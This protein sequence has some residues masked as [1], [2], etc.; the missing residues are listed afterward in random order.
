M[1]ER[2]IMEVQ[3]GDE[4]NEN[5][6][7]EES[8]QSNHPYQQQQQQQQQRGTPAHKPI[9]PPQYQEQQQQQETAANDAD[10]TTVMEEE[11]RKTVERLRDFQAE[12]PK[13]FLK[14]WYYVRKS[15][16]AKKSPQHNSEGSQVQQSPVMGNS[17]MSYGAGLSNQGN[18]H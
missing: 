2:I 7:E 6:V 12:D 9:L 4:Q 1:R 18:S 16:G 11:M 13:L 5:Y 17:S 10:L 15:G 3:A 8:Q 14:V